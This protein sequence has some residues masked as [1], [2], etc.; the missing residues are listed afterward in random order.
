MNFTLLHKKNNT[1]H[2]LLPTICFTWV[3]L[4]L[5]VSFIATPVKFQAASLTLPVAMAVGKVTFHLFNTVEWVIF[6]CSITL[7]AFSGFKYKN[8]LIWTFLLILLIAQTHWLM[9]ILDA[10]ADTI[11]ANQS[12]YSAPGH[13][14]WIYVIIEFTKIILLLISARINAKEKNYD[15]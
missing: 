10:R 4:I 2:W 7:M 11:I 3:G 15:I 6:L 13:T 12:E 1:I 5:G 14:H 9:P 8:S